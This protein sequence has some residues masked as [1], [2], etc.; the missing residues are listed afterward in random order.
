MEL[1]PLPPKSLDVFCD[2]FDFSKGQADITCPASTY[3]TACLRACERRGLLVWDTE[4]VGGKTLRWCALT[5]LGA[6]VGCESMALVPSGTISQRKRLWVKMQ[7]DVKDVD[8]KEAYGIAKDLAGESLLAPVVRDLLRIHK[9][10]EEGDYRLFYER[11]G[12]P[13]TK[14]TEQFQA[15]FSVMER[16]QETIDSLTEKM[17]TQMLSQSAPIAPNSRSPQDNGSTQAIGGLKGI[18]GHKTFTAPLPSDDEDDEDLGL[19]IVKSKDAGMN[20]T[21]NFLA[22]MNALAN[23]KSTGESTLTPRQKA[24]LEKDANNGT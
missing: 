24:R 13:E 15:M 9:A 10:A 23:A 19:E 6:K 17:K 1:K 21:M 7:F 4:R 8:Y 22:S 5:K 20:A 14:E 18:G 3:P 11:Y 12:I 16:M 2:V